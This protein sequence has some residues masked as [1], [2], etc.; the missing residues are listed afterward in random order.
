MDWWTLKIFSRILD[1]EWNFNG[2]V[3]LAM[4]VDCR[5]IHFLGPNF[6]LSMFKNYFA[7]ISYLEGNF[8]GGFV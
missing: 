7:S 5:F 3:D 8:I 1:S 4:A 2:F 6:S